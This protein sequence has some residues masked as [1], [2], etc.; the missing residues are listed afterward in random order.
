MEKLV[1]V[2]AMIAA[3]VLSLILTCIVS[4]AAGA[5]EYR[6]TFSVNG[7][8]YT[9]SVTESSDVYA[10]YRTDDG[11]IL[12]ISKDEDVAASS[13]FMSQS[14]ENINGEDVVFMGTCDG[15]YQAVWDD[16]CVRI[17]RSM[18]ASEMADM[19]L[20]VMAM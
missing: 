12:I 13:A 11:D 18:T 20:A 19:V 15:Y 14:A 5:A 10:K 4:A 3:A 7:E 1:K 16:G 8:V 9:R 17:N 6:D 2:P